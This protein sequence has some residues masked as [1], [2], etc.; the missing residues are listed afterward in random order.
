MCF[1][2]V[3]WCLV[4][5]VALGVARFELLWSFHFKPWP[6]VPFWLVLLFSLVVSVLD[7][8]LRFSPLMLSMKT[9]F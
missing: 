1:Y 2:L 6:P 8:L 7:L 4:S 9:E 5:S 3:R